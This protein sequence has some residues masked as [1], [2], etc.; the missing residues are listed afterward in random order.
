[1][2]NIVI[3]RATN[4]HYGLLFVG[5][6]CMKPSFPSFLRAVSCSSTFHFVSWVVILGASYSKS[7]PALGW[8]GVSLTLEHIDAK[9]LLQR[10]IELVSGELVDVCLLLEFCRKRYI[11]HLQCSDDISMTVAVVFIS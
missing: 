2:L 10:L 4:L 5:R 6:M 1:M 8:P 11:N 3:N 9:Q 7:D